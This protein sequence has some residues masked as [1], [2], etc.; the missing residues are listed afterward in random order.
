M[1]PSQGPAQPTVGWRGSSR[2]ATIGGGPGRHCRQ[3]DSDTGDALAHLAPDRHAAQ[4]P[5][6]QRKPGE[7]STP[8]TR[9][10]CRQSSAA[11]N[12]RTAAAWAPLPRGRTPPFGLS[13]VGL[14]LICTAPGG[15]APRSPCERDPCLAPL[16]PSMGLGKPRAG[17]SSHDIPLGAARPTLRSSAARADSATDPARG[18]QPTFGPDDYSRLGQWTRACHRATESPA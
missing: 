10:P 9:A 14:G 2:P 1:R 4:A 15:I 7:G 8:E 6:V 5:V 12:P 18:R 11:R 16:S 17:C 3:L 13:Q